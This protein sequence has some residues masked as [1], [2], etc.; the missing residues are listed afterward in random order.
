MVTGLDLE[1]QEQGLIGCDP[2]LIRNGYAAGAR[3]ADPDRYTGD[4]LGF[5]SSAGGHLRNLVSSRAGRRDG[6]HRGSLP[7]PPGGG[8]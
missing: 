5:R 1:V 3:D 8:H 4:S 7:G 6:L 2:L